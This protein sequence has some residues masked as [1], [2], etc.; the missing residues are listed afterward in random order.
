MLFKYNDFNFVL[1]LMYY[2]HVK[3]TSVHDNNVTFFT[4]DAPKHIHKKYSL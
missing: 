4:S 1:Y 3:Y 2:L